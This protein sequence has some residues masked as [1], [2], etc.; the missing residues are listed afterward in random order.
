MT[1]TREEMFERN[2]ELTI[3]R[4]L[5]EIEAPEAYEW[6]PENARVINLPKD[7][8]ALLRAN[9]ELAV[10]LSQE[11]DNRPIVLIPDPGV[12]VPWQ[13]LGSI[14][15]GKRI[16]SI[17]STLS[18]SG[19]ELILEDGSRLMLIAVSPRDGVEKDKPPLICVGV[20]KPST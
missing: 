5:R 16:V 11:D 12:E 13:V 20:Q 10:K 8:P 18:G 3:Q 9:L 14:V 4:L 6:I 15:A 1:V 19:F 7:D 17:E 2:L